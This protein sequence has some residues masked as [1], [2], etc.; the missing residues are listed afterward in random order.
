V[1]APITVGGEGREDAVDDTSNWEFAAAVAAISIGLGGLLVF[2]IVGTIGSWRIVD[3][4]NRVADEASQASLAVQELARR[5]AE[6]DAMFSVAPAPLGAHP[7]PVEP[8]PAPVNPAPPAQPTPAAASPQDFGDDDTREAAAPPIPQ[9]GSPPEPTDVARLRRDTEMLLEQQAVL[10][11]AV[12][13]LIDTGVLRSQGA[14]TEEI[15]GL[16][17]AV[18]RIDEQLSRIAEAVSELEGQA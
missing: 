3:R 4:V 6:R 13:Q 2:T 17:V 11:D 10:Q 7:A 14:N 1:T 12:H 18:R 5:V 8:I 9:S 16:Q 15:R